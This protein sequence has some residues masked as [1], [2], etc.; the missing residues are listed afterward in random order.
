[1]K[2]KKQKFK[3]VQVQLE[4]YVSILHHEPSRSLLRNAH[5]RIA[6]LLPARNPFF[7]FYIIPARAGKVRQT[8]HYSPDRAGILPR[9]EADKGESR[10]CDGR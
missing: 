7:D 1:L 4:I 6:L 9:H 10:K 2:Q 3:P 8:C 5:S